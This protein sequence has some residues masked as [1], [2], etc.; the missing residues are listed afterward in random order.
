MDELLNHFDMYFHPLMEL[1][2][3]F[4]LSEKVLSRSNIKLL[5]Y[6]LFLRPPPVHNNEN[7]WKD[8]RLT[9]FVKLLDC[10]DIICVQELFG[11]FNNRKQ[12]LI[13]T[14]N[15][16]GLFFYCDSPQPGFFSK[17]LSDGGLLILSRF[18]ILESEFRPFRYSVLSDSIANKGIQFA[19]IRIGEQYLLLFNT[20]TQASYFGCSEYHWNISCKTRMDHVEEICSFVTD[21]ITEQ[22][23]LYPDCDFLIMLVGD[24]NIDYHNYA[25]KRQVIYY[26]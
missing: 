15:R 25:T 20:H 14:A 17:F 3:K 18:P 23:E 9:D 22:C 5:T 16:A 11:S 8:E 21:V 12:E 13:Q 26:F 4:I 24:L 7:D 6:N 10:F 2:E 19:K 1:K